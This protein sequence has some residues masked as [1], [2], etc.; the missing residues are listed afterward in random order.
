MKEDE[1]PWQRNTDYLEYWLSHAS[2]DSVFEWLRK[3][4]PQ[5]TWCEEAL[6]ARNEPLINLGLALWGYDAKTGEHLFRNGDKTIKKAA[7]EGCSVMD[8][9]MP[10]N[11]SWVES[12]GVL[13][14]ILQAYNDS[15]ISLEADRDYTPLELLASFLRNRFIRYEVLTYLYERSGYFENLTDHH[16]VK[17]IGCTALNP[18]LRPSYED[19]MDFNKHRTIDGMLRSAWKLFETMPVDE[20]SARILSDIGENITTPGTPGASDII[21]LPAT[22]NRWKRDNENAN[23]VLPDYDKSPALFD[24]FV[25][26]RFQLAKHLPYDRKSDLKNSDDV[27]LRLAYYADTSIDTLEEFRE[28]FEKDKDDFLSIA[29]DKPELYRDAALRKELQ[30]CC[31]TSEFENR[32]KRFLQEHPDWFLVGDDASSWIDKIEDPV[33]RTEK[34]LE[35]IQRKTEN[36][37]KEFVVSDEFVKT[38]A[39]VTST[40][41]DEVKAIK[42]MLFGM[43]TA[44][45]WWRTNVTSWLTLLC[46]GIIGWPLV[47]RISGSIPKLGID[48]LD[49]VIELGIAMAIAALIFLSVGAVI[50]LISDRW[51][52]R[53]LEELNSLTRTAR[54]RDESSETPASK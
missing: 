35:L 21:D 40:L 4:Q 28:Y 50:Q 13:W 17:A 34:R 20:Q 44:D 33:L 52:K 49:G 53:K 37:S 18:R 14:E 11:P 32:A 2:A 42:T 46:I 6:I 41:I 5:P 9:Y 31:H 25:K 27:A 8:W 48:F 19:M 22:I 43:V 10:G 16:W 15:D 1:V 23:D 45:G 3:E 30:K 26:C 39:F 38:D 51:V 24:P 47:P 7:L 29:I 36:I 54:A 12:S